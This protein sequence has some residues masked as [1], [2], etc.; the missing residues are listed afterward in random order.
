MEL[1]RIDGM[2]SSEDPSQRRKAA[3]L[4]AE[5]GGEDAFDRL[6]LL[7]GDSNNGVRDAAQNTIILLGSRAAIEKMLP[8]LSHEDTSI[9][10][11]AIDILRKIGIDG[12]DM[13]H[14]LAKDAD[15]NVRLFVLDIL[16][17]IG[18]HESLDTLIEGLYDV[19]PNVRNASVISLGELGDS[20][21]FDH[22]KQLINDEEWIR[23]SVIESLA[24]IPHEGVVDFLLHELKRW[25]NDEITVCAIL[26]ALG[27][28]GSPD[29]LRPLLDMLGE[30]LDQYVGLAVART[31]LTIMSIDDIAALELRD[32]H[33]LK[34]VL[35][36]CLPEAEGEFLYRILSALGRIGDA[37]SAM[38]IIELS[39]TIEPDSHI[40]KWVAIKAA[41][42]D[43]G[44][45]R[46]MVSLLDADEKSALL[47]AE[48]LGAIGGEEGG[49]EIAARVFSRQGYVKRAMTESLA[50]IGGEGSRKIMLRLAGDE[51]GH[52]TGSA[53]RA[54]GE[55]GRPGDIGEIRKFLRHAFPD[56]R[57]IALE[58][59]AR[60]GTEK[61]EEC[62]TALARDLDPKARIMALDGLLKMR[63]PRLGRISSYLL[64]DQDW[65]VRM[66]AVR[67]T[68]DAGLPIENDLLMALLN[69]EH[70]EIRQPA[71]DIVGMRRIGD[72]RMLIEDAVGS[73]E[74]WTSYHAIEALGNF[75]DE[76]ARSRLLSILGNGPDFLRISAAKALGAWEDETLIIELEVYLDDENLDVAR[77]AAEA[78][79]RLQGVAF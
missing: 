16:G 46:L 79:N 73:G 60:I 37:G 40:D 31:L 69:D 39:G 68:R 15:D 41:L 29:A 27:M 36:S 17:S 49:R 63:S 26:E 3:S 20:R 58:A 74:M 51:D 34:G 48:I 71:I 72:L 19:N 5:T 59:I 4:L 61:A 56:V 9:R 53:L 35:E 45:V 8:L 22:L 32:R 70:D 50:R 1:T 75:R 42:G 65:E 30:G 14:G 44:D 13:L 54:L 47:G 52:V 2:I 12:V 28:L 76:D 62:F 25:Q 43:L 38:K 66:A 21:S 33:L 18:S 6:A 10:N 11:T 57:N 67:I 23:F 78:I 7:L 64:K 24:R 77:A 55:I